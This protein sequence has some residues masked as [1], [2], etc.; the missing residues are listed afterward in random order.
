M[1]RDLKIIYFK[2][3]ASALRFL[4]PVPPSGAGKEQGLQP[5]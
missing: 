1:P 2:A 3:A 4:T 5:M